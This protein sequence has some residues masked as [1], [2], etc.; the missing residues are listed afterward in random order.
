MK[1]ELKQYVV[2]KEYCQNKI[3]SKHVC[4]QCGG[5]I[6]PIETVDNAG[7]P[8]YWSGCLCC[9]IF[10][11]GVDRMVYEIAKKLYN[12]DDVIYY[13]HMESPNEN[14]SHGYKE[15]Y[16]KSQIGG[17]ALYIVNKVFKYTHPDRTAEL[18]KE[19]EEIKNRI[20]RMNPDMI[21]EK[22]HIEVLEINNYKLEKEN[23][24]LKNKID[25]IIK[26][27]EMC[28]RTWTMRLDEVGRSDPYLVS[29]IKNYISVYSNAIKILTDKE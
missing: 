18:E 6:E 3:N 15:Y 1:E 26:E 28:K 27:Y 19:I 4:R 24:E 29:D 21:G 8:T 14:K 22:E 17:I 11:S 2:S 23:A 10:T 9:N 12:D 7:N 13:N 16:D 20:S 5:K 25:G